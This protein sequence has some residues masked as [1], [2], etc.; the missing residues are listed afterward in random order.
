[1]KTAPLT[2]PAADANATMAHSE[3]RSANQSAQSP[4]KWTQ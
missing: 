2:G 4:T 1:M 3:G